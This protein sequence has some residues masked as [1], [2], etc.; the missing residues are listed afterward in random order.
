M[1]GYTQ[2]QIIC[3]VQGMSYWN[4]RSTQRSHEEIRYINIPYVNEKRH[5]KLNSKIVNAYRLKGIKAITYTKQQKTPN[6]FISSAK[7]DPPHGVVYSIPRTDCNKS[8]VGQANNVARRTYEHKYALRR[9]DKNSAIVNHV[10]NTGHSIDFNDIKILGRSDDRYTCIITEA[11]YIK[12]NETMEGNEP[13][14][15]LQMRIT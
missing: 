12:N 5:S 13:D 15:I 9:Q 6:A 14:Y 8:Y 10:D 3:C 1:D 4:R 11:V 7:G 2:K